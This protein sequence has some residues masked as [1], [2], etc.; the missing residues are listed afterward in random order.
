[1]KFPEKIDCLVAFY[2]PCAALFT[3]VYFSLFVCLIIYILLS[4]LYYNFL[5]CAGCLK[6]F[7]AIFQ[8]LCL[9]THI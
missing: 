7:F 1:M 6:Y 5:D 3:C 4:L 2:A 8:H 9:K